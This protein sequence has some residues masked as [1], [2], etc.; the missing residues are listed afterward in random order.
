MFSQHLTIVQSR[1]LFIGKDCVAYRCDQG[2]LLSDLI[3]F[4]LRPL[5]VITLSVEKLAIYWQRLFFADEPI[6]L[7]SFLYLAWIEFHNLGG[8]PECLMV[9]P[10]LLIQ[11]RQ[12]LRHLDPG[13]VVKHLE[14]GHGRYFGSTKKQSHGLPKHCIEAD[15]EMMNPSAPLES[16]QATLARM[17]DRLEMYHRKWQY[18]P[19]PGKANQAVE[20]NE[21]VHRALILPQWPQEPLEVSTEEWMHSA[22]VNTPTPPPAA[23]LEITKDLGWCKIVANYGWLTKKPALKQVVRTI[24][25]APIPDPNRLYWVDDLLWFKSIVKA[26]PFPL[27]TLF[28]SIIQPTDLEDFLSD[29]KPVNGEI[30]DRLYQ[31]LDPENRRGLVLILDSALAF[32]DAVNMLG[33]GGDERCCAELVGSD[34]VF[35]FRIFVLDDDCWLNILAVPSASHA[36]DPSLNAM[37]Y[38]TLGKI[39]VGAPGFAAINF[40]LVHM[41]QGRPQDHSLILLDMVQSMLE[42][43]PLWVEADRPADNH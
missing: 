41:I 20:F 42:T 25:D 11:V 29:R 43:V 19:K 3:R 24:G 4:E 36:N 14:P 32:E 10:E 31:T 35:P 1:H 13:K 28:E 33:A 26:L 34:K 38:Q 7:S 8:L 5:I 40:W 6:P 17:N 22:S 37:L 12:A 9:Q 23:Q 21:H 27:E 18:T 30:A 15:V 16:Q 39:D 2:L